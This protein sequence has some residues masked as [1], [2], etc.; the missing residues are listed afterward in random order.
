MV[1]PIPGRLDSRPAIHHEEETGLHCSLQPSLCGRCRDGGQV[2]GYPIAHPH[3][4][5]AVPFRGLV[6]HHD[7]SRHGLRQHGEVEGLPG[8]DD[9]QVVLAAL[10]RGRVLRH[11]LH[12]LLERPVDCGLP[13]GGRLLGEVDGDRVGGVETGDLVRQVVFGL[14]HRDHARR[15]GL[16]VLRP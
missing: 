16:Q 7:H 6:H 10:V 5:A 13:L 1:Q 14:P 11:P 3:E 12:R 8:T 2:A 9:L 15:H 4:L